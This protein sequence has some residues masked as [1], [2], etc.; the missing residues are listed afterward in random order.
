MKQVWEIAG[1]TVPAGEKLQTYIEVEGTREVM[2]V[3]FING[4]NEGKTV[5]MTS[6]IHGGEYE[7]IRAATEIAGELNPAAVF[8]QLARGKSCDF[9]PV[10]QDGS[11]GGFVHSA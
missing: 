1:V 10:D 5:L 2:P 7:G 3:T 6:G 4:A 8:G 9:L 11:G